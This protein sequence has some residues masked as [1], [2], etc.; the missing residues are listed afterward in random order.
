MSSVAALSEPIGVTLARNS[1]TTPFHLCGLA[2]QTLCPFLYVIATTRPKRAWV[3]ERLLRHLNRHKPVKCLRQRTQ[4]CQCNAK[5]S[6]THESANA[7]QSACERALHAPSHC[8]TVAGRKVWA[9]NTLSAALIRPEEAEKCAQ[10]Q[11]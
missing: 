8:A 10:A 5:Q 9:R 7:T 1:H 6:E 4:A 2:M 11:K 3:R